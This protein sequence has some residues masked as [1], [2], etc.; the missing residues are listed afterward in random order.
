MR[1]FNLGII[2]NFTMEKEPKNMPLIM[3]IFTRLL[4]MSEAG[5]FHSG[6]PYGGQENI[7]A[8][9]RGL[10][11]QSWPSATA[12]RKHGYSFWEFQSLRRQQ[13]LCCN[14]LLLWPEITLKIISNESTSSEA[15]LMENIRIRVFFSSYF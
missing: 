15:E 1:R 10:A 8:R 7:A 11:L 14:S 13:P 5:L 12:A 9:F 4:P 6:H 3:R 2:F